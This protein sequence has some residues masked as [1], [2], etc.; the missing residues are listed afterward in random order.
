MIR[1]IALFLSVLVLEFTT[2]SSAQNY[3]SGTVHNHGDAYCSGNLTNA[4]VLVNALNGKLSLSGN[5]INSGTTAYDGG[6]LL[7][8]GNSPQSV[9]GSHVIYTSN[10]SFNNPSGITLN[11]SFSVNDVATFVSGL[12]TTPAGTAEPLEFSSSASHSGTSNTSHVNGYVRKL[13]TGNFTYPVGD[14]S[15]YEQV[16]VN[17]AVNASGLNV[18]YFPSDAGLAPFANTGTDTLPLYTYNPYEYWNISPVSSASG[19]VTLSWDTYND[20]GINSAADLRVAHLSGGSWLNEGV[21][22]SGT[23]SSGFVQSNTIGIAGLFA[24]G[25]ISDNSILPIVLTNFSVQLVNCAVSLNW[26]AATEVDFSHYELQYTQDGLNFYFLNQVAPKGNNS[27]Y[28][29]QYFPEIKGEIYYRLKM[30]DLNGTVKYSEV[31]SINSSCSENTIDV[32]PN[33]TS[34]K[35]DVSLHNN[36]VQSCALYDSK[37]SLVR[38]L[39]LAE[40]GGAVDI[41]GEKNGMYYLKITLMNG[42]VKHF[43]ILLIN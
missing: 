1:Y 13:G 8:V 5:L 3:I 40:T 18:K 14:A 24:L 20:M 26:H 31:V 27:T 23:T 22:G 35:F 38:V 29:Y 9:G 15:R 2:D 34:G 11:K 36:S 17:A 42:N 16:S 21:L 25:S 19:V 4:G 28:T 41:T 33:Y 39:T 7:F 30:V 43:K 32:F 10:C 6:S 12:I 37:G